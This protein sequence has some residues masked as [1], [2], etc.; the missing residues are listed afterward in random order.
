MESEYWKEKQPQPG[1]S[2][3][4]WA[5]IVTLL[6]GFQV[7]DVVWNSAFMTPAIQTADV[8]IR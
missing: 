2:I 8:S 5:I 6:L 4:A 1:Q 3:C 7:A